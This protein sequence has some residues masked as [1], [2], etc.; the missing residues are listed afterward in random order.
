MSKSNKGNLRGRQR[1]A[2][3]RLEQQYEKFVAAKQD[4]Q[5]WDTTRNGKPKHHA[6][7]SYEQ[8]CQRL[9]QEILNVKAN[10]D[11]NIQ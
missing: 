1:A 8:E 11:R 4:K 2:L 7:R 9:K 6:G 5:P 10:L 3:G